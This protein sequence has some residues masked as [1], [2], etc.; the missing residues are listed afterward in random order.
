MGHAQEGHAPI[1]E[2]QGQTS[3]YYPPDA[4]GSVGP[5]HY[6]QT[7]NTVYSIYD[8]AGTLLAGPTNMNLL[9]AGVAGSEHNDGDPI[10]LYDDQADRW[11]A[12][13]FAISGSNDSMMVAVSTTSDPTG[14][15]YKY[16]FDVA[17]LPDYPKFGVWRDGY[18]MGTNNS[19]GND[20]YVFE[21]SQMLTGGTAHVVGF[22]NPHRPGSIDG[23]MCVPQVDNDGAFAP[24]GSPGLF[25]AFND[26]AIGGGSDQLWIYALSVDWDALGNSTFARVQQ[27]DVAAFDSNFG[28]NWN[29]I[30]QQGT[31][32]KLD[33]IPQ[34]IMNVPQYRNFGS[35]ETIVCC[36]TVDVDGTNHAGIRWYELRRT[37]SDW[38]VRQEGTYAPDADSR[39]M[40]SISLNGSNEIA[41]G[42]SVSSSNLYP[43]IRYCGQSDTAYAAASGILDVPEETILTGSHSQTNIN[44][45][46]DYS[47]MQVD[48]VNDET[49]WFT[50]EYIG[51]GNARQ[52]QIASFQIGP[53]IIYAEFTADNH[54]PLVDSTVS[55]SDVSSGSPDDWDWNISPGT[56]AFTSGTSSS[57]QNPKVQFTAAGDYSVTLIVSDGVNS[58][59]ITKTNY[60]HAL[61]CSGITLP[62]SEDFSEGDLPDCWTSVDHEGNGQVWVF[63]NPGERPINTNTSANGFAILDSDHYGSENSQDADLVTPS[64]DFY[65]EEDITLSFDHYFRFIS[66]SSGTLSYSTDG[67]TSWTVLETWTASTLNAET[68]S[69]DVSA[70]VAGESN[71][72]FKWN[73]S[74]TYGWYW[75][76]D[77]IS[78]TGTESGVWTGA[79]SSDWDVAG[80]WLNNSLPGSTVNVIIPDTVPNW[81]EVSGD[82]SLGSMCRNVTML[83]ASQLTVNGS[84]NIAGGLSFS[85][86]DSGMV[87][88][89]GSLY[90]VGTF[91]PGSGTVEFFGS[92]LD[93]VHSQSLEE[94]TIDQYSREAFTQGMTYLTG[95]NTGPTGDDGYADASLGFTFY[96]AGVGY[97]QARISTNGWLSLDQSGTTASANGYLFTTANPNT[98]LAP[99]FDNLEADGSSSVQYKTEGTAPNRVFTVEWKGVLTYHNV[100]TARIN[101]QLKLYESSNMIEFR[102]GRSSGG[103]PQRE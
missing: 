81:P 50:T 66:G 27:I 79:N 90:N 7:I 64:F 8:K 49:F 89:G 103:E 58:D 70:E 34:V 75:A 85:M 102:Y 44:R 19:N 97:T 100:A 22:D 17:D 14:T 84:L 28:T 6:M 32:Q 91:D 72:M 94:I 43:G 9:F 45:W 42:Y 15:W 98:T 63:N 46:G 80:N 74:G 31:P 1:V 2:V 3:P 62:F 12:A 21:R 39:W 25:I 65:N 33:A 47:A 10:V 69:Q 52:T 11:L 13:E 36:H 67:G 29:N 30:A 53:E 99:W 61:D 26:D 18:Y 71:V 24:E 78:I 82:L 41:L 93:T 88:V 35:Y 51:S 23:F 96:Y 73:Y 86:V 101:F 48:P 38:S 56:Y 83:G 4:N 92:S 87:H 76:V 77:D 20:I 95:A 60:I 40:G 55:F 16:S 59:T 54:Y 68:Y 57:S 37:G 5:N